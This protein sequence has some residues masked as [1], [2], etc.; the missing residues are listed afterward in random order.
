MKYDNAEQVFLIRKEEEKAA[1]Q[2]VDDRVM[3]KIS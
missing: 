1:R 2:C 3:I